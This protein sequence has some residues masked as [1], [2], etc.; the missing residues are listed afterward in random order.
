M[1]D[2]VEIFGALLHTTLF[3]QASWVLFAI[4]VEPLDLRGA[5]L[6]NQCLVERPGLFGNSLGR[7]PLVLASLPASWHELYPGTPDTIYLTEKYP[8]SARL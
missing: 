5:C 2:R 6:E 8:F 4:A 1:K 3:I 7:D